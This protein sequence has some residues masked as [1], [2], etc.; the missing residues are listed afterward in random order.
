MPFGPEI[1]WPYGFRQMD[2]ESRDVQESAYGTGS[3]QYQQAEYQ[4]TQDQQA[5]YQQA[6]YQQPCRGRL[7]LR[8]SGLLGPVLR[9]PEDPCT[10]DPR[11]AASPVSASPVSASPVSASPVSASPVSASTV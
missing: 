10:P 6:Q 5:Q 1:S 11:S 4:Q 7:R 3:L 9:R 8:G 2:D